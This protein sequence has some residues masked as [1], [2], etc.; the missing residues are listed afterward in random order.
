[1]LAQDKV[2]GTERKRTLSPVGATEFAR[3]IFDGAEAAATAE[4]EGPAVS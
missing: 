4:A 1:M 3:M 2:L